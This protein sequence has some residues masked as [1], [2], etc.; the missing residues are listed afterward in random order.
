M[1][2]SGETADMMV[3]EGI[4]ITESAMKLAGLGAKNLAAFLISILQENPKIAGKTNLRRLLR[5][6]EELTVISIQQ[7]D[8]AQFHQASKQYG[9]L[10]CPIINQ[11]AHTDTV[12]LLVKGKDAPQINHILDRFGC[13]PPNQE[14]N[15][16]KKEPS[17]A[18]SDK[19]SVGMESMQT[20]TTNP[21]TVDTDKERPSVR[22]KMQCYMGQMQQR[23]T[24]TPNLERGTTIQET[25]LEQLKEK[26]DR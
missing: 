20:P 17:P 3:R 9:I 15:P 1:S 21:P 11:F 4:Q 18:P 10:Y 8:Y 7:K 19:N 25:L 14:D 6:H 26:M 23:H 5:D 13:Q 24:S 12:E 2:T 22:A 16:A